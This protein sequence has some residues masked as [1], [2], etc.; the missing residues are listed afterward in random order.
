MTQTLLGSATT[1]VLLQAGPD[2]LTI[3]QQGNVV[4]IPHAELDK[5][6]AFIRGTPANDRITPAKAFA[7]MQVHSS[8]HSS[9]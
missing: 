5:L 2:G 8:M 4:W 7:R 1:P 3:R 6:I 9:V